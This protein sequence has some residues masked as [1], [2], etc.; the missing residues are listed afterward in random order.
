MELDESYCKVDK[1]LYTQYCKICNKYFCDVCPC[2]NEDHGTNS[3]ISVLDPND[4]NQSSLQL[5]DILNRIDQSMEKIPDIS[6]SL[7]ATFEKEKT[8]VSLNCKASIQ[9]IQAMSFWILKELESDTKKKTQDLMQVKEKYKVLKEFIIE[10]RNSVNNI[11]ECI[12][13]QFNLEMNVSVDFSKAYFM[14]K[15]Y[16]ELKLPIMFKEAT[17]SEKELSNR[18]NKIALKKV[19]VV[20]VDNIKMVRRTRRQLASMKAEINAMKNN[21]IGVTSEIKECM[22]IAI[23]SFRRMNAYNNTQLGHLLISEINKKQPEGLTEINYEVELLKMEIAKIYNKCKVDID[24]I[25]DYIESKSKEKDSLKE[26]MKNEQEKINNLN[27]ELEEAS[28]CHN[29]DINTMTEV[30]KNACKNKEIIEEI[31]CTIDNQIKEISIPEI[32]THLKDF[33]RNIKEFDEDF[34]SRKIFL[35]KVNDDL[36]AMENMILK[37]K[38]KLNELAYRLK[39]G[40]GSFLLTS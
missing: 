16:E 18:I 12:R 38:V 31:K 4:L 23:D 32:E 6:K 19:G 29:S 3:I 25:N 2:H 22:K 13:N 7:M 26:I 14:I 36:K 27:N 37:K 39:N 5:N 15:K 10:K 30:V 20:P 21:Y 35:N 34:L 11:A 24:N 8:Q 40:G 1:R 17:K 9:K 28:V 33:I